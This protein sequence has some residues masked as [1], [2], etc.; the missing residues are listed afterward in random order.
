MLG[1]SKVIEVL[2]NLSPQEVRPCFLQWMRNYNE[3]AVWKVQHSIQQAEGRLRNWF[4]WLLLRGSQ[5]GGGCGLQ[6]CLREVTS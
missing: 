3:G 2:A 6:A 4:E 1:L 5:Q